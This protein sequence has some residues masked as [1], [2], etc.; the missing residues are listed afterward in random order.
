M[1][2]E[3]PEESF[4]LEQLDIGE[5]LMKIQQ[6]E[7]PYVEI[8]IGNHTAHEV[9]LRQKT[10][11]GSIQPIANIVQTDQP[12]YSAKTSA[13]INQVDSPLGSKMDDRDAMG[14]WHPPVNL[15]HLEEGQQEIVRG[16]LYEES[17]AFARDDDDIGCIPSLQ[18]SILVKDDIP[19]QRAYA[20]VPKPLY[21]EVK[22]YVQD[23]LARGW[24]VKSVTLLCTSRVC[25]QEG[26]HTQTLY[27]LQAV[28]PKDRSR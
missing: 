24:I 19:V 1:L 21:K 9:T 20:S 27:R 14:L 6:T 10:P 3:P 22:E 23:L 11:L 4:P 5:G 8:P 2:F 15:S 28:K 12:E 7:R 18:M 13:G 26:W 16:M 25:P 17:K